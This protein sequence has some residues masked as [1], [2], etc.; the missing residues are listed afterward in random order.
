MKQVRF[1]VAFI[2]LQSVCHAQI[3]SLKDVEI[4]KLKQLMQ[5]DKTVAAMVTK[6]ETIANTALTATPNPIDT[7][8]SEGHLATDPKKIITGKALADI[9][10]IYA[11]ALMYRLNNNK[12]YLN[13][14]DEFLKAWAA[15]NQPNGNPIN[16]TK[17]GDIIE[18]YDLVKNDL[19]V[20]DKVE[21]EKWLSTMAEKEIY[22]PRFTIGNSAVKT[23]N[24]NSHRIKIIG[25]IAYA[26]KNTSY[27]QFVNEAMPKQ[28]E[29]NLYANGSGYDFEER[30]ALHYH[31]YTLEPLLALAIVLQ[32]AENINYYTYVSATGSSIQKSV[33]FLLPFV[34]GEKT[35]AE[36][37]NSKVAFDK[38]RADNH[39]AGFTTGALFNPTH[40]TVAL[41]LAAWFQPDIITLVQKIRATENTYP[42]WQT[43]LNGVRMSGK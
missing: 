22:S 32:R 21:I 4:N 33:A 1:L 25:M 24:W 9:P 23:N 18:A 31:L 7:V 19:P 2:L 8:V 16:D 6:F 26:L 5:T 27:Q 3:V 29:N 17:F 36:F 43:V 34:T 38:R 14:A 30:D 40:A 10:K 15:V 41:S 20:A 28:I 37:V 39:E 42:N 11:L 12:K 35:H 13:K